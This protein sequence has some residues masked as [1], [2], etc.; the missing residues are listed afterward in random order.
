MPKVRAARD[1]QVIRLSGRTI[2]LFPGQEETVTDKE[3]K[4]ADLRQ[5]IEKGKV[6]V[7]PSKKVRKEVINNGANACQ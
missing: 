3:L 4:D 1:P 6:I 5:K 7:I 2:H